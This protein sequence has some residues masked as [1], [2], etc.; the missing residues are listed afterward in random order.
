MHLILIAVG[1]VMTLGINQ[2]LV[3]WSTVRANR[4]RIGLI[5]RVEA[6]YGAELGAWNAFLRAKDNLAPSALGTNIVL[7]NSP[8]YS[9]DVEP[10]SKERGLALSVQTTVSHLP[11][12]NLVRRFDGSSYLAVSGPTGTHCGIIAFNP[13]RRYRLCLHYSKPRLEIAYRPL[14]VAPGIAVFVAPSGKVYVW[15]EKWPRR[16]ID[17]FTHTTQWTDFSPEPHLVR[18]WD[19]SEDWSMADDW[20]NFVGVPTPLT[21][22]PWPE[23]ERMVQVMAGADHHN[24]SLPICF[25][26]ELGQ[27]YCVGMNVGDGSANEKTTSFSKVDM[28]AIPNPQPIIEFISMGAG[29]CALM[30]DFRLACWGQNIDSGKGGTFNY[31][32]PY[33]MVRAALLNLSKVTGRVIGLSQ[34]SSDQGMPLHGGGCLVTEDGTPYC[35][36]PSRVGR[37]YADGTDSALIP[38][39]LALDTVVSI[40]RYF[41]DSLKCLKAQNYEPFFCWTVSNDGRFSG[42][43]VVVNFANYDRTPRQTFQDTSLMGGASKIQQIYS[44]NH[45]T[46]FFALSAKGVLFSWTTHNLVSN[47]YMY[48]PPNPDP[49][50]PNIM[51]I[52]RPEPTFNSA[53]PFKDVRLCDNQG[54]ALTSEDEPWCWG[55]SDYRQSILGINGSPVQESFVPVKVTKS[56]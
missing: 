27:A 38:T 2:Q 51:D 44:S 10:Y 49:E 55:W 48:R 53:V 3:L 34:S 12:S 6:F 46:A 4:S 29:M 45:N 43:K 42:T 13:K 24:A 18:D 5:D 32:E 17:P 21:D 41:D 28:S 9:L 39:P 1:I 22:Y 52:P 20:N 37:I 47:Y 14:A 30:K 56:W 31:A 11:S 36:G 54:C 15:G 35:W 19:M 25:L 23:S 16:V 26:S 8:S 40:E 7:D 50:N 33:Y